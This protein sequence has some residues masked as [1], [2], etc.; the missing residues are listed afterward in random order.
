MACL[1]KLCFL[2]RQ[3]PFLAMISR[4]QINLNLT[5]ATFIRII[6]KLNSL[7]WIPQRRKPGVQSMKHHHPDRYEL[8]ILMDCMST[9]VFTNL[10]NSIGVKITG[11]Y[12]QVF[13]IQNRQY[14][15]PPLHKR[16]SPQLK[17]SQIATRV[18]CRKRAPSSRSAFQKSTNM[19]VRFDEYRCD[20]L[21][22]ANYRTATPPYNQLR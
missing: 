1:K 2:P 14:I 5:C 7:M 10:A 9:R 12:I 3:F 15:R 17:A 4:A 8:T 6:K 16:K 20:M 13:G 11:I 18:Q 22:V 21:K 19:N